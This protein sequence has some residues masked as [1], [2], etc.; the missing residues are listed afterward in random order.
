[1]EAFTALA[2]KLDRVELP[3]QAQLRSYRIQKA[4]PTAIATTLRG[5]ANTGKLA[6]PPQP[7][8]PALTPTIEVEPKSSTL[9]VAGDVVTFERV[10]QLLKELFGGCR[11]SARCASCRSRTPARRKCGSA[12]WRSTRRRSRRSPAPGRWT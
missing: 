1:M 4:D 12:R 7:G 9:I 8:K 2:E 10:E 3:E 5:L 11:W 6:G